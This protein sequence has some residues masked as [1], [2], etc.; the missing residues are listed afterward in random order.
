MHACL[1]GFRSACHSRRWW[2]NFIIRGRSR[3]GSR[4]ICSDIELHQI[5][6][7]AFCSIHG[8]LHQVC[9]IHAAPLDLGVFV[10][11]DL[12]GRI[13]VAFAGFLGVLTE[14]CRLRIC[15]YTGD[16]VHY[17]LQV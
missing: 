1:D 4:H 10:V 14:F 12:L 6:V 16:S 2:F 9:G 11:L 8:Y 17:I 15:D 7:A 13:W 5:C 3:N